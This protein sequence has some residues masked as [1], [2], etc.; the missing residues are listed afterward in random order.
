M[1]IL[2]EKEEKLLRLIIRN[3]LPLKTKS[4]SLND[5]ENF[6]KATNCKICN[7]KFDKADRLKIKNLDHCHY[8]G[9]YRRAACTMCNMLS[10]SQ[11]NIPIYFHNFANYDSKLIIQMLNQ[12]SKIRIKPK[13]LFSNLQKLRYLTFNS[14]QFKDS[15][16]HLPSP[17]F[18]LTKEL[19]NPHQK[20]TFSVLHIVK[21][22]R[23]KLFRKQ[24]K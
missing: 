3:K 20:P 23:K 21:M 22:K 24:N 15:L 18:K 10:R 6:N 9:E 4:L 16:E 1:N 11:S 8:S 17:L 7:F 14:Y 12:K 5:I 2:N 13:F 19:N